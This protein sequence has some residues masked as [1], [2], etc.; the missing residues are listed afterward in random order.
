MPFNSSREVAPNSLAKTPT[1][2]LYVELLILPQV[3]FPGPAS[4]K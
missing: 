1:M 3:V 2:H 4:I